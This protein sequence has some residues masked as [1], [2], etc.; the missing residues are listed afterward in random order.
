MARETVPSAYDQTV[1]AHYD[2]DLF[3]LLSDSR[4]LA[5]RQLRAEVP[6]DRPL[7]VVDV[8]C[9][10]GLW[11][12]ELRTS[13]PNAELV[14]LDSSAEML[15]RAAKRGVQ[16]LLDDVAGLE[17]HF[18]PSSLDLVSA[19]YILTYVGLEKLLPVVRSRLR[20]GGLLSLATSTQ[21]NLPRV[22]QLASTV[23]SVESL[24]ARNP[25]PHDAADA[26]ARVEA[27][28]LRVVHS[29]R[30]VRE[31]VF[32]S[33]PHFLKFAVDGGWLVQYADMLSQGLPL[34]ADLPGLL[35][36][37]DGHDGIVLLARKS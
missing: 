27:A 26:V 5:L 2:D 21:Q 37:R 28:G 11:L 25:T 16:V 20:P 18:A 22:R 10:T 14:G 4:A 9:G 15:K 29:D 8:G 24:E 13:F 30:L 19:H 12:S 34:V 36:F 33:I 17:H 32:E 23:F 1:A 6:S 3:S 35:P 31:L 7:R